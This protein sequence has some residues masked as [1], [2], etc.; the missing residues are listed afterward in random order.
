MLRKKNRD[1]AF[2]GAFGGCAFSTIAPFNKK[3][4]KMTW[5]FMAVEFG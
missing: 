2:D 3:I 1:P 5:C 4:I